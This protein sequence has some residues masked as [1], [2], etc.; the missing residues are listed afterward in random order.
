MSFGNSVTIV[1]EG[2]LGLGSRLIPVPA[3][4][5]FD[6]RLWEFARPGTDFRSATDKNVPRTSTKQRRL[7]FSAD[8]ESAG[9]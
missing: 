4:R 7:R 6:F 1:Q 5:V 9:L 2:L 3:G 8:G